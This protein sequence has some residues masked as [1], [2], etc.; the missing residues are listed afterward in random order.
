M[1]R[2]IA[3][4][5]SMALLLTMG[6]FPANAAS[7]TQNS[8]FYLH[9][10]S[11]LALSNDAVVKLDSSNPDVAPIIYKG[12]TLVPLRAISEH[13]D[14]TVDYDSNSREA[15][16]KSSGK[17]AV[18]P[19]DKASYT[20]DGTSYDLDCE[21]IIVNSRT[22]V[23]LRAIGENVLGKKVEF[24]DSVIAITD[25]SATLTDA[26]ITDIKK[27][28]ATAV[29]AGSMDELKSLVL[30]SNNANV[31]QKATGMGGAGGSGVA[32]APAAP[33][34]SSNAAV[35]GK[36]EVPALEDSSDYSKTNTQVS[37]IDEG[38]VVK[39]DGKNIYVAGSSKFV[40]SSADNGNMAKL[41]ETKLDKN[42][43]IS[44]MYVDGSKVIIIG[45]RWEDSGNDVTIQNKMAAVEPYPY[46]RSRNFTF[47][48]VY[49]VTD[50][51]APALFK[52]YEVE[53]TYTS[54][55]KNGNNV[56]LISNY[57]IYNYQ[58]G[59]I[60]P[61][62]SESASGGVE[63]SMAVDDIMIFPGQ[64]AQQYLTVSALDISDAG[65]KTEA[66]AVL[67]SGYTT[68]MNDHALYVSS[69]DWAPD[70]GEL[71]KVVKFAV[72]GKAI[73]Y[74]GSNEVPGYLLN[75]F[76][77]DEYNGNL[78]IATT[79][80]DK[81]N[82][83]YVFGDSMNVVGTLSGIAKGENI[84]AV[85]FMNSVGYLVTYETT[86]PLFVVDLSNPSAPAVKG[87]LKI[88]GFSNYLHPVGENKLLGIGNDSYPI[89]KKDA[90]G[91]DVEIGTRTGG[92][93]LSLFDVSDMENPKELS[94]LVLGD[95]GSYT[96][97]M[98]NHKA[99]MYKES[100]GLIGF[101]ANI[102]GL[103]SSKDNEDN[104][105]FNGALLISIAGDKLTEKGRI[106][107]ADQN[108]NYPDGFDYNELI[109]GRRLTY[110]GDI[111]YYVQDGTICS[112][113]LSNLSQISSL[114]LVN[115]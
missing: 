87:E 29:K 106:K 64:P 96:E 43:Y 86:D 7:S 91:N 10:G 93:K 28:I 16:I 81:G 48:K 13:F 68:Y 2:K 103:S 58:D 32:T 82:N 27:R 98:Y 14:A 97:A 110:I 25:S 36:G 115:Y 75:Q 11:P 61:Y 41:S 4:I 53:G 99:L 12:R 65:S 38:D 66:E 55:R 24:K 30:A 26:K 69:Y 70:A 6:V 47:I 108:Y 20:I 22:M 92:L 59:P 112:Y 52:E 23:P 111:L 63:T 60:V 62:F 67:G 51:T 83:I 77:M 79:Q 94:S 113:N 35:D 101:D 100:D 8:E 109:Y 50:L 57:Y 49:D 1:K 39:T 85:R 89:Y 80:W 3:L 105:S 44:D 19:I 107:A 56:Y 78:R 5:L 21:S 102:N 9:I 17:T 88:P 72:D 71:T 90:N 95:S 31:D 40:I 42:S 54:S 37:G 73:S 34:A 33:T 18:F 84:Y 104:N 76:S 74:A 114:K 46:H 15:T 45:N